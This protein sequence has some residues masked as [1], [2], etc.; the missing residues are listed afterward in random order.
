MSIVKTLH[1]T[2][3]LAYVSVRVWSARKLDRRASKRLTDEAGANTDAA[4]VNKYL[5]ASADTQL[6]DIQK[7]A[8]RAR[9]ILNDN[10]LPWDDAGN[11]LVANGTSFK[12]LAQLYEVENEFAA[13]VDAFCIAYPQLRDLAR[14]ALGDMASDEDYPPVEVVRDKFAIRSSLTPLPAGFSDVRVG[15]S[16]EEQDALR[17]HYEAEAATRFEEAMISAW[18]RLR[19]NVARYVDRLQVD[20]DGKPR[21]FTASMVTQLRDTMA[22]LGELNVFDNPALG[23][24]K[25]QIE[26]ALCKHDPEALRTSTSLAASTQASAAS[27]LQQ[28]NAMLLPS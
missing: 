22:L 23:R 4:R 15:L 10:S 21:V 1:D 5:L 26:E 25:F 17:R 6:R 3:M 13:A 11:R 19:D 24:L 20:A 16:P 7:I 9:D 8:R 14:K 28:L 12:L 27:I 2:S 18:T